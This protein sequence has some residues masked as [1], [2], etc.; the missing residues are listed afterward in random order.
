MDCPSCQREINGAT[1]AK[2]RRMTVAAPGDFSV[3]FYCCCLLQF[4]D[5]GAPQI[6]GR[7]QAPIE[8]VELQEKLI[9]WTGVGLSRGSDYN[10]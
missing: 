9:A 2:T 4:D 6:I 8:L 3:C 1:N 7:S 5:R 10:L